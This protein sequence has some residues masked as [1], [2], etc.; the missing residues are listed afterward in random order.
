V[1]ARL[2][3]TE[4]DGRI[5]MNVSPAATHLPS[6]V[7]LENN[8]QILVPVRS[9]IVGVFGAVY[10]PASFL[11]QDDGRR[12]LRV[13]DYIDRAGGTIRG[14]DR[15][16]I[17]VVRANGEVVSRKRGSLNAYVLPGDVVFVPVKTNA[18]SFW[19]KLRELSTSLFQA[20]LSAATVAAIK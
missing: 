7:L 17:F 9:T 10:R 11:I 15:S 2:K 16:G 5:V 20:G 19:T 1:L 18:G 6:N 14:A 12:P 3:E 4:P 13:K 8:D